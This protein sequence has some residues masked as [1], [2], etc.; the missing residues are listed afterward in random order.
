MNWGGGMNMD[1][2][3]NSQGPWLTISGSG[4]WGWWEEFQP[5][6]F[7]SIVESH[8]PMPQ[9]MPAQDTKVRMFFEQSSNALHG[10]AQWRRHLYGRE[11][12]LEVQGVS[13]RINSSK[14]H[15]LQDRDDYRLQITFDRDDI[16]YRSPAIENR[17]L[18]LPSFTVFC[19]WH[20]NLN[21]TTLLRRFFFLEIDLLSKEF[22]SKFP[23]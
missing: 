23:F 16:D 17:W 13:I 10:R 12:V 20:R 5:E 15:H 2:E 6:L 7:T 18:W 11:R 9:R 21:L 8:L 19:N 4:E 14:L 1:W 3:K 22:N